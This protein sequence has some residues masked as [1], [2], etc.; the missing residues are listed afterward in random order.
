VEKLELF[1]EL[2]EWHL[3]SGHYCISMA[4]IPVIPSSSSPSSSDSINLERI[5]LIGREK[6]AP[7]DEQQGPL[8]VSAV[9]ARFMKP[10][11]KREIA[12]TLTSPVTVGD[13]SSPLG[14]PRPR[15]R[16]KEH[17]DNDTTTTS[18]NT[19]SGSGH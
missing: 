8:D 12:P 13:A 19:T 7:A 18:T 5:G 9:R 15:L 3:I 1:D 11:P 17:K 2:E 6:K 16:P 10:S 4:T 14:P